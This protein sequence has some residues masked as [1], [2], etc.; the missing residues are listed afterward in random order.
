MELRAKLGDDDPM[1][2]R[3]SVGAMVITAERAGRSRFT[4]NWNHAM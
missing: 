2:P 1:V 3:R 4:T